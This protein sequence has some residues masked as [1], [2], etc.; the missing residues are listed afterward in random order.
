MRAFLRRYLK[1]IDR[2][3]IK[4]YL[5]TFAFTLGIFVV[6]T[7]VFD[8]SEHI[9][10]FLKNHSTLQEIVFKYYAG[11]IPFYMNLLSPLINFLAVIYFTAKMANQTE[12]VPIL[13]GKA[14]FSRFLRPYFI[15]ATLIFIVSLFANL[16]LIPFTNNLKITFENSNQF[17]GDQDVKNE[18]HIQ[19]D[20]H[21]FVYVQ[22]FDN[23]IHTGYQFIMEKFDGDQ[24]REKLVANTIVYDS[25]KRV[26]KLRAYTI[27]YVNGLKEKYVDSTSREKDTVLDMRPVD[28]I[29][30]DNVYTAMSTRDLNRN[31]EKEKIRGTGAL[32]EMLY[33]KYRRFVYPLSSY[34]LTLIG[35]SISSRKVR[36]GIGLPLGI[37]IF[38]CFAYIVIDRFALVFAVK[39]SMVPLIA[40]CMPNGIF[41]LVG[42]YLLSKAP[43]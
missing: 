10:N 38:L 8:I 16:Y 9:D 14:S 31:I 22:S 1:T 3:I 12:I 18:V 39:G 36:G 41:A 15:C 30:Y 11:F 34:V 21:T 28:F 27:K 2:Y 40:V 17:N 32:K 6:I 13:S 43:K 4:K 25:V 42:L 7:V 29:H 5:G 33:E 24:L 20:K 23:T 35:V 19:L 26:W 37:G